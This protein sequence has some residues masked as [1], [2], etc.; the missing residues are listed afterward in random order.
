[1]TTIKTSPFTTASLILDKTSL[2]VLHVQ[3]DD[4]TAF[5]NYTLQDVLQ[6]KDL[7]SVFIN[8]VKEN[9]LPDNW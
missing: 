5:S 1:M 8:L 2:Y 6:D 9:S 4:N 3:Y 7:T